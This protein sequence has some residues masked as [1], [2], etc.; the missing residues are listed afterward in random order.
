[1]IVDLISTL[2]RLINRPAFNL[3]P[4]Q[5]QLIHDKFQVFFETRKEFGNGSDTEQ[6]ESEATK[7][8]FLHEQKTMSPQKRPWQGHRPQSRSNSRGKARPFT[9]SFMPVT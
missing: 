6:M 3:N 1:L 4:A 8:M 5:Q 9:N 2:K 7:Q